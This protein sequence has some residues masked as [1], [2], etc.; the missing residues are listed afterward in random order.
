MLIQI[1]D[2]TDSTPFPNLLSRE[3]ISYS[4][5]LTRLLEQCLVE[6]KNKSS[7]TEEILYVLNKKK[8]FLEYHPLK[9]QTT[10]KLTQEYSTE[11]STT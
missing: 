1:K 4:R 9:Y 6:Y 8:L 2:L 10:K 11:D 3:E 5:E 7:Q